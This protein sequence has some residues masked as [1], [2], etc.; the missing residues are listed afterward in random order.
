MSLRDEI[1]EAD[2]M[3]KALE[4]DTEAAE[5]FASFNKTVLAVQKWGAK[6]DLSLFGITIAE[7]GEPGKDKLR[8]MARAYFTDPG[9]KTMTILFFDIKETGGKF[10]AS[11]PKSKAFSKGVKWPIKFART[12]EFGSRDITPI[13]L[14][15]QVL[16]D[17]KI[18]L[19]FQSEMQNKEWA[20]LPFEDMGDMKCTEI[21]EV[22]G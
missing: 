1:R 8:P 10:T 7:W 4:K 6:N 15:Y 16:V 5:A 20:A 22:T 9:Y 11:R 19:P 3:L 13:Y 12:K 2:E 18:I 14:L 21:Q 17:R